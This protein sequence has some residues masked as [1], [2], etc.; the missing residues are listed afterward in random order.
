[1]SPPQLESPVGNAES[2]RGPL[3]VAFFPIEGDLDSRVYRRTADRVERGSRL[4]RPLDGHRKPP[5]MPVGQVVG[6]PQLIRG[7]IAHRDGARPRMSVA[8]AR[9]QLLEITHITRILP[10][11]QILSHGR[12]QVTRKR[13]TKGRMSS[14][15]SRNGASRHSRPAIR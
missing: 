14:G 3:K 2:L 7:D 9:H 4:D 15:R 10:L 5:T 8:D 13:L 6:R 12:V 1:M 11:E